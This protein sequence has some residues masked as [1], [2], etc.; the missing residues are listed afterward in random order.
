MTR[1]QYIKMFTGLVKQAVRLNKE[2]LGYGIQALE[3][4]IEDLDDE[5]FKHGL[6]FVVDGTDAAIIDE[7]LSNK[8][9][10]EKNKYQRMYMTIV[11]RAVM[12]IQEGLNNR[13]FMYVLLSLA[14]LSPKEQRKIEWV[15][16]EESI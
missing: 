4:E 3:Y 16:L 11:K 15:L 9:A 5:Y 12:G 2:R 1:K 13:I 7:I 10:F 14:G 8:L 6:R